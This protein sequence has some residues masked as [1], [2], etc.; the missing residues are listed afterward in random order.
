MAA[1]STRV[2][3]PSWPGWEPKSFLRWTE[4]AAV[5]FPN[6][7]EAAVLTGEPDPV[8]MAARLSSHYGVVVVK[9]GGAGCVLATPGEAPVLIA[10]H[11]ARATDTTGAGD[12]FCGAFMSKWLAGGPAADIVDPERFWALARLAERAGPVRA[13]RGG[14]QPAVRGPGCH[15]GRRRP[16]L[17]GRAPAARGAGG[18]AGRTRQ[19]ILAALGSPVRL[20]I[21]RRLLLGGQT[22]GELQEIPGLGTSGQLYHHLRDLQSAGLV[23]QRR[24]GRYA[25]A[26]DK[27]VPALVII[28]AAADMTRSRPAAAIR[29]TSER[30]RPAR[31]GQA[32]ARIEEHLGSLVSSRAVAGLVYAL[33]TPD[34]QVTG[35]LP[36]SAGE[37]L[38]PH[39]SMEIG[40]IT[41]VFTAL[42][43]ADMTERGQAGLDDPIGRHLPA[44]VADGCP[45]AAV[46]TL[47]DLATHTSGL[48]RL[49]RNLIPMALRHPSDPY[50]R[51]TTAHLFRAVRAARKPAV[52]AYLYS[53]FGFGLLGYLLSHTAGRS[54]GELISGRVHP[55]PGLAGTS[56]GVRT[57]GPPPPGTGP[58]PGTVRPAPPRRGIWARWPARGTPLDRR[59]PGPL[60]RGQPQPRH[61][62]AAACPRGG[63]APAAAGPGR[64][65]DRTGLACRQARW[66]AGVVA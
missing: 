20:E 56:I 13:G 39:V 57:A 45:A 1:P 8:S 22:S 14:G 62:A 4:G 24:R 60:P 59:R 55:H 61:H 44:E 40:S 42:L 26:A 12:A 49:P 46:I 31:R 58:L 10:A 50:A 36:G 63:P 3:P 52:P 43:L 47:R 32:V 38:G 5:C 37:P 7:D 54:Y 28:A 41:K 21:V 34:G 11:P 66:P 48:P 35:Q 9:L 16:D 18:G 65:A 27:V 17:A 30:R 23:V 64:P 2:R 19:A 33:V 51:Y 53:N 6:R 25:V 15:P 29:V